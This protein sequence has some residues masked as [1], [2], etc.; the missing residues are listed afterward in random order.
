[1]LYRGR[2]KNR[3]KKKFLCTIIVEPYRLSEQSNIIT[4][5][6]GSVKGHYSLSGRTGYR[7]AFFVKISFEDLDDLKEE[8]N[9]VKETYRGIA[10]K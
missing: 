5:R 9:W 8:F 3:K 6:G 2:W 1:M 10:G 4:S 7:G